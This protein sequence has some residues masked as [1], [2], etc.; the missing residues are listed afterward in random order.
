MASSLPT[1]AAAAGSSP[2]AHTRM[3]GSDDRS[4]CFLSSV[5]SQ[6]IDLYASSDSLILSSEAV[7]RL[8]PLPTTAQ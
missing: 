4:M 2:A 5:A 1:S 6:A 3:S 8:A 7:W